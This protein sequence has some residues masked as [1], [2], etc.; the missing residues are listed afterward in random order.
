[1]IFSSALIAVS[2][3]LCIVIVHVI[4]IKPWPLTYIL[5]STDFVN[6]VRRVKNSSVLFCVSDNCRYK[7]LV[8]SLNMYHD[9]VHFIYTIWPTDF[10]KIHVESRVK[11]GFS[12]WL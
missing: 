4:H 7:I 12:I 10:V 9:L 11:V 5:H 2:V 3:K 6:I 1:M 8:F